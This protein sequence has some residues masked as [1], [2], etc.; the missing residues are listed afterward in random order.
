MPAKQNCGSCTYHRCIGTDFICD[1][2][3]SDNYGLFTEYDDGCCDHEQREG[4]QK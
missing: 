4:E 2:A 1:N 3:D